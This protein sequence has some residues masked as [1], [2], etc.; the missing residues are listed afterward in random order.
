MTIVYN[1]MLYQAMSLLPFRVGS[2][3]TWLLMILLRAYSQQ[4]V[5]RTTEAQQGA[6]KTLLMW[7]TTSK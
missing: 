7:S 1:E 4:L 3:V 6:K 5:R 2:L